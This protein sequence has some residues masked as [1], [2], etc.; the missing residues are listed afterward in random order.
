MNVKKTVQHAVAPLFLSIAVFMMGCFDNGTEP[1]NDPPFSNLTKLNGGHIYI[2]YPAPLNQIEKVDTITFSFKYNSSKINSI[3]V[4]ATL[5]SA[6]TWIHIADITPTQSNSA[7]IQW[8]PKDFS[9]TT[10][11]FFGFKDCC[12]QISDPTSSEH[13]TSDTFQTIGAVPVVLISPLGGEVYKKTDSVKV[14]YSHNQDLSGKIT[15]CAKAD[16]DSGNWARGL[17]TATEDNFLKIL[18]IKHWSTTFV[19]EIEA[20]D[21][22]D[23]F[24]FTYPLLILLADYGENGWRVPSGEITIQ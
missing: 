9:Q 10:F 19:P 5:D 8:V 22:P 2:A 20:L 6:K 23:K 1:N 13:I 3:L 21:Q 17:N 15:V 16:P 11:N 18:P 24:D 7:S 14:L 12:I 4:Q